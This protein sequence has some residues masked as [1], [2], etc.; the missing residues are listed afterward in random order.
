MRMNNLLLK[1]RKNPPKNSEMPSHQFLI[2]GGYI[3]QVSSGIYTYLPLGFKVKTNIENIIREEMNKI[4]GQEISM[5]VVHPAELWKATKRFDEVGKELL[6]FKD[7]RGKDH[8][9]AMTHEETAVDL[10]KQ[11]ISSYKELPFTVYHFQTKF[12]DEL[13]SRGGLLRVR[14]F[15]MKDAYSYHRNQESLEKTYSQVHKAYENMFKRA[16]LNDFVSVESAV[17][18]MGGNKAH[19]FIAINEM[20]EDSIIRCT[21]C[22]YRANIEVGETA[23]KDYPEEPKKLEKIHTPEAKTIDDLC[24]FLD[25][26]R[27]KTAKAV[28]FKNDEKIYFLLIRGDLEINENKIKEALKVPELSYAEEEDIKSI[29]AEPGYASPIGINNENVEIYIDESLMNTN[30]LVTG[31]NETNYHY[32]N[33]NIKRDLDKNKYEVVSIYKVKDGDKC[34]R[35]N[36]T[37]KFE[38]GIEIGNIFQ[39]GYKYSKSTNTTYLDENGKAQNFIMASYGIGIGR[40]MATI[41]EDNHDEYGPIWPITVSPFDVHIVA[42]NLDNK[43][44]KNE[45]EKIYRKLK[46]NNINVIF[47]DRD[48]RAGVQF[49]DADLIGAPFRLT[50]SSRNLK[51]SKIEF[52]RRDEDNSQKLDKSNIIKE[53]IDKV[54]KEYD[55]YSL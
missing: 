4:N 29:G 33:F 8:V 38:N 30:N 21:D 3:N 14:E 50:V 43:K 41:I 13:R 44:V 1:T 32:K 45:A 35:C 19:E 40:L 55:K 27:E 36:G 9:I 10:F 12:R 54:E 26:S 15:T 7:R 34:P 2:R 39:L 52:K 17:G 28:F 11:N 48:E 18:A 49:N 20:G 22:S 42:I 31:A 46:E 47:D 51:D 53:I 6:R 23:I 37:L 24:K 25:I 5:P 16:G